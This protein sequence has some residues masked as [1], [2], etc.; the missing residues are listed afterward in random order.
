MRFD[1]NNTQR[2]QKSSGGGGGSGGGSSSSGTRVTLLAL[3]LLPPPPPSPPPSPLSHYPRVRRR[4]ARQL[5]IIIRHLTS[6][7]S[8]FTDFDSR[9]AALR[10]QGTV[11]GRPR[12][13]GQQGNG[14]GGQQGRRQGGKRSAAAAPAAAA[15]RAP[16]L[17][18]SGCAV[19]PAQGCL[20]PTRSRSRPE[21]RPT[22]SS[23]RRRRHKARQRRQGSRRVA[24]GCARSNKEGQDTHI[25]KPAK[26]ETQGALIRRAAG[27]SRAHLHFLTSSPSSIIYTYAHILGP[28]SLAA[29]SRQRR[30][31]SLGSP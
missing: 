3:P 7:Y 19:Q 18:A 30:G 11:L 10:S 23:C 25:H 14:E 29:A 24:Q 4:G 5:A 13:P 1:L 8:S 6:H 15:T 16:A 31:R 26:R 27:E 28:P 2:Q 20:P 17:R 12:A 22:V 21:R 9:T